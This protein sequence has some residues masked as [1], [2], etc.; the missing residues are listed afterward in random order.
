MTMI[1]DLAK[2]GSDRNFNGRSN[3]QEGIEYGKSPCKYSWK[4]STDVKR[5]PIT[6]VSAQLK[7]GVKD[8]AARCQEMPL[9]LAV[10]RKKSKCV[11]KFD[12]EKISIGY[13]PK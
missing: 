7:C 6:L 12:Q 9:H 1:V 10:L 3:W 2:H 13:Y 4:V 8:C 5:K 11:W